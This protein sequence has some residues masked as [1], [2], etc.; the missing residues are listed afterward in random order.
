MKTWTQF[1]REFRSVTL[2]LVAA[3]AVF[4]FSPG[5][6]M[7][8][9]HPREISREL[10]R[11]AYEADRAR[12]IGNR[13]RRADTVDRLQDRLHSLERINK[14][15]DGQMARSNDRRID[16]LQRE[17][18]SAGASND[19]R[20]DRQDGYWRLGRDGRYYY[21]YDGG[22]RVEKKGSER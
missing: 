5:P 4:G 18:R 17:L 12:N 2:G 22:A 6:A 10:D 21:E 19:R 7:A 13:N 20:R 14:R 8:D 9:P 11:I 1:F 16:R 3:A 15:W